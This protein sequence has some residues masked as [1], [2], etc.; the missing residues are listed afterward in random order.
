MNTALLAMPIVR[1]VFLHPAQRVKDQRNQCC[2]ARHDEQP[3][4]VGYGDEQAHAAS[5]E[6]VAFF[7][8]VPCGY[9]QAAP[10][11]KSSGDDGNVDGA[12]QRAGQGEESLGREMVFDEEHHGQRETHRAGGITQHGQRH[13]NVQPGGLQRRNQRPHFRRQELHQDDANHGQRHGDATD[14]LHP[15]L[16]FGDQGERRYRPDEAQQHFVD[17]GERWTSCEVPAVGH[18]Q[19]ISG[20]SDRR[21]QSKRT[22]RTSRCR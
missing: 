14:D 5:K 8:R 7:F 21:R 12:D 4:Q 3:A 20:E 18:G 15:E 13:V 16:L 17:A 1:L 10:L 2:N 11:F 9:R 6:H 22:L 19:S